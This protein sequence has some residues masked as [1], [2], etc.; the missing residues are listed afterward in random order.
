VISEEK[1]K[2]DLLEKV[3]SMEELDELGNNYD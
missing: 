2:E 1:H 3:N